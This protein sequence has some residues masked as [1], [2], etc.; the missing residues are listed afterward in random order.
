MTP[1]NGLYTARA[2]AMF[3]VALMGSQMVFAQGVS[4]PVD[5]AP[6]PQQAQ[7]AAPLLAPQQLDNL[8]APV[9]LYPDPLLGQVL[10]A[11]TY[12][13]EVVEA[14]RWLQQNRGLQGSQL[15]AAARQQNWDPSVEA[16]VAFP[17]VLQSAE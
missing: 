8:V 3:C 13:L 1:R 17:D 12:P 15:T 7:Q 2:S 5:Q 4:G 10:A 11:S 16:L 6:G 14:Q 9:A